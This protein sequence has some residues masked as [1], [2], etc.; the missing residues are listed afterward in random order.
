MNIFHLDYSPQLSAMHQHDK[1]V[2]KMTLETAQLVSQ[3]IRVV[4]A[5]R[6]TF[7]DVRTL[8][9]TTHQHHPSAKWARQ[10]VPNLYWL[11][12]HGVYLAEEYSHRFWRTHKSLAIIRQVLDIVPFLPATNCDDLTT[13]AQAMPDDCKRKCPVQGYRHYYLTHKVSDESQWTDRRSD[14]PS[15]LFSHALFPIKSLEVKG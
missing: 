12:K 13:F 2:V 15:W 3:A 6:D 5:W 1:H 10:T 8:Y 14:L 9:K 7:G 4:P 11:C